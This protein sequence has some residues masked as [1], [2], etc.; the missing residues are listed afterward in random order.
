MRFSLLFLESSGGTYRVVLPKMDRREPFV[1][2]DALLAEVPPKK[3]P[4]PPL[5]VLS[6]LDFVI[7]PDT[8]VD[9]YFTLSAA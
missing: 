9:G 3:L 1:P 2:F 5:F 6:N 7:G 8:K 4:N